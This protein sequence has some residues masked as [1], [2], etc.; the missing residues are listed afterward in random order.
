VDRLVV[1]SKRLCVKMSV[2]TACDRLDVSF[3]L[4]AATVL[5]NNKMSQENLSISTNVTVGNYWPGFVAF[6]NKLVDIVEA[7]NSQLGKIFYVGS[8]E[9]VLT[10]AQVVFVLGIEQVTNSFAINFHV[11]DLL[12]L[13]VSTV[14]FVTQ[15]N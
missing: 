15:L 3:M 1:W 14:D 13:C 5:F 10:Y 11:T 7:S 9:R 6:V 4:V 8:Q 12:W 2:K